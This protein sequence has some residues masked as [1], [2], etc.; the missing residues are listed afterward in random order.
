M[1]FFRNPEIRKLLAASAVFILAASVGTAFIQ[2]PKTL[3]VLAV[4]IL[5]VLLFFLFTFRRYKDLSDLSFQIDQILHENK[6]TDFVP[7]KEGELALLSSE[8]Y[9][10][11]VRL[12]E[13]SEMLEKE[14]K[15]LSDS[16]ADI[17]H[18]IRTPLTSI[19]L[20]A[21]RLGR[22]KMTLQERKVYVLEIS[23]LLSRLEWLVTAMLKIARLESGTVQLKKE[24]VNIKELAERALGPLEILMEL[25][26]LSL[27]TEIAPDISV[28][29]DFLWSME[30]VGNILKNCIEHT[31][32][33]GKIK[34]TANDNPL[35]TK[36]VISDTGP[37]FD[38]EDL[39]HLFERFYKGKDTGP[40][41]IGIGLALSRM[42]VESQN[43]TLKAKNLDPNGAEFQICFY[44]GAI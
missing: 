1:Q 3:Y 17:S 2:I 14:K 31:P 40:E 23:R 42:I 39:P 8:I 20:I 12:Q 10:M 5:G 44:K 28:T 29:G 43:G 30:A 22:E 25:R 41:N 15:Y 6:R 18:Q 35:Y 7:E 34:I 9:K 27:E 11:T 38:P 24:S 36:M 37:G 33:G 21:P 16:M 4:C 32:M 26:D 19:R 13:Q